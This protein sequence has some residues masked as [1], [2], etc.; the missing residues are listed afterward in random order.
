MG[1]P[2]SRQRTERIH[3]DYLAAE[4]IAE[5]TGIYSLALPDNLPDPEEWLTELL[6]MTPWRS[7]AEAA[8]QLGLPGVEMMV[9]KESPGSGADVDVTQTLRNALILSKC[10]EVLYKPQSPMIFTA[11]RL[12]RCIKLVEINIDNYYGME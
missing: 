12:R 1:G 10:N 6:A 3:A 2:I 8:E 11:K 5:S 7:F 4:G 9:F